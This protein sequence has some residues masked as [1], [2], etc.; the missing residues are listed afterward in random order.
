MVGQSEAIPQV[1]R[2]NLD[3]RLADRMGDL[4]YRVRVRLDDENPRVRT[5]AANLERQSQGRHSPADDGD[6][7][8]RR[9]ASSA[10]DS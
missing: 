7:V 8:I 5:R 1:L 4:W 3:C 9:R 6:I 10:S 2:G